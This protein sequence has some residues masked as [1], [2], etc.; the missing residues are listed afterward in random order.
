MVFQLRYVGRA[1][2]LLGLGEM[3]GFM[4]SEA[5]RRNF[6]GMARALQLAADG[7]L[8]QMLESSDPEGLECHTVQHLGYLR[9]TEK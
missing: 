4:T 8:I 5:W 9:C 7:G 2:S 1:W 6:W 3:S